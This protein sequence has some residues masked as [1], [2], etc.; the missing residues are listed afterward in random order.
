M[1]FSGF[2]VHFEK[3]AK[4]QTRTMFVRNTPDIP[5]GDY[6]IL[7][8]FCDGKK[9]DCR[10]A[11]VNVLQMDPE[12]GPYHAATISYGWEPIYFY[13]DWKKFLSEKE[14]QT[15]VGPAIDH[16]NEQSKYSA[17]IL[18][19][20]VN[21]ALDEEYIERLKKQ[22]AMFKYKIGM[23]LPPELTKL[24]GIY[25]PCPCGSGKIFKACCGKRN[26]FGRRFRGR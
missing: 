25:E 15:F 11:L 17:P 2:Q 16:F 14:F 8:M 5:D 13:N 7:P 10:R 24:I 4:V 6:A 26:R 23:K 20:F 18:E 3:I 9:C 22:Y 19:L 1:T 21:T 12:H